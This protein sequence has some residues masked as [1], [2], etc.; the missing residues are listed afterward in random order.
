MA[1]AAAAR[2]C[3]C[4][5]AVGAG[6]ARLGAAAA[7]AAAESGGGA[8]ARLFSSHAAPGARGA[9]APLR[10]VNVGGAG[11]AAG[12]AGGAAAAGAAAEGASTS[13]GPGSLIEMSSEVAGGAKPLRT[14][15][16]WYWGAGVGGVAL[17]LY[18]HLKDP[19][20]TPEQLEAAKTRAAEL[21]ARRKEHLRA[22]LTGASFIDGESDPLEGLTP[23]GIVAF[24]EKHGIDPSDPLE[25][26]SPDEI[27]AYMA[28]QEA[29]RQPKEEAEEE[30]AAAQ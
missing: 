11:G 20:P 13:G 21:E 29:K 24:M 17:L 12:G 9:G 14:W 26:L 23:A 6:A 16:K 7:V 15:E 30:A 10:R 22:V 18:R 19:D 3:A 28:A 1:A 25:G 27:D 2:C 8:A 4:G 5:A